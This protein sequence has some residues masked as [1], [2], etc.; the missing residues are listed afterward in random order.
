MGEGIEGLSLIVVGWSPTGTGSEEGQAMAAA[1]VYEVASFISA[2]ILLLAVISIV[3][4]S[5]R[6]G[7]TPMPASSLVRQ[8]VSNVINR[9]IQTGSLVEAGSGWGTLAWHIAKRCP[10]WRIVGVE[11]SWIPLVV[12]R[13]LVSLLSRAGQA[14]IVAKK[15]SSVSFIQ[16]DLY[17]YPYETVDLI[18]CYLY[19][20]A[21]KRLSSIFK[22]RLTPGQRI[23]SVC[24]AM[25]GWEPDKV[26][27]CK[28]L[29][30]TPIYV[31]TFRGCD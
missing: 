31:Y 17:K 24:F 3:Y 9:L 6:N 10:G 14:E 8:E 23:I 27:T 26:I 12:S 28:D 13:L 2:A 25:P 30:R 21:M 29:Y 16:G 11:N 19:P 15:G 1:E 22:E 4:V 20:G 5:W 7:I 18:I